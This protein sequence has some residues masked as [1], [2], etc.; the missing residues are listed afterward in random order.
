MSQNSYGKQGQ[1]RRPGGAARPKPGTD[2]GASQ[3]GG[4]DQEGQG[5]PTD[6]QHFLFIVQQ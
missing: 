4:T 1:A 5:E 3:E 2:R 6:Q